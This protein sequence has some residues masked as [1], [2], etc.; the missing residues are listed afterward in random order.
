MGA[1]HGTTVIFLLLATIAWGAMSPFANAQLPEFNPESVSSSN[2]NMEVISSTS[3]DTDYG[4]RFVN[5]AGRFDRN[6]DGRVDLIVMDRNND[7]SAD[8]WATDRNYDGMIDDF[9]YDRNFNGQIDQWEYDY[10]GDGI[11]DKIYV[12]ANG[13]GRAEMYS[14]WNPMN[15]TYIWYGKPGMRSQGIRPTRRLASGKIAYSE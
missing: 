2:P 4:S 14:E 10:D 6:A 8:Y 5:Q 12:D 15:R 13:D 7:R 9:Q 1:K 11:P 3:P